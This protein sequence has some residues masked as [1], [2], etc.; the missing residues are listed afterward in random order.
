MLEQRL[1]LSASAAA[2]ATSALADYGPKPPALMV[3]LAAGTQSTH[4]IT[5]NAGTA[6]AGA[7]T[8]TTISLP[9]NVE[10]DDSGISI[11]TGQ[12]VT[13]GASGEVYIGDVSAGMPGVSNYQ[14]P[15]GDAN[16]STSGLGG[17]PFAAPGLVPWS[18]VGRI[19]ATGTPFEIG[20]GANIT[21][22]ASGEL[23]LSV[24][25]NNFGDNSGSWSIQAQVGSAVATPQISDVGMTAVPVAGQSYDNWNMTIN[26]SGFGTQPAFNGDSPDLIIGDTTQGFQAGYSVPND[27]VN[28]NVTKLD[29]RPDR[30]KRVYGRL[31]RPGMDCPPGRPTAH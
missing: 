23:Y 13:I 17:S 15:A 6:S 3:P 31:R 26:G 27:L 7:G 25:D 22:S 24:N 20:T 1:Y 4:S 2:F 19:G 21:A 29:R 5:A 16:L 14:S 11:T 9:A 18:L 8:A 30:D 12:S 28:V 10:W